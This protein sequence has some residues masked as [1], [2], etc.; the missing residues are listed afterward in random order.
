MSWFPGK[1]DPELERLAT[2]IFNLRRELFLQTKF[3]RPQERVWEE[4]Y[5]I[6]A[7]EKLNED[8]LREWDLDTRRIIQG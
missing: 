8:N 3:L 4:E 6:R 2:I 1:N 5:E 7:R